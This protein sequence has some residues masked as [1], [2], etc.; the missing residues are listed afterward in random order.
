MDTLLSLDAYKDYYALDDV[1][2]FLDLNFRICRDVGAR[3]TK[4][5]MTRALPLWA[6]KNM[7][8]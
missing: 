5:L 7:P 3:P 6:V 2:N 4:M 1:D 8:W